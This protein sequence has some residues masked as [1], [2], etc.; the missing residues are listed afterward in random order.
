[1][2][3]KEKFVKIVQNLKENFL[4]LEEMKEEKEIAEF[5]CD[6]SDAIVLPKIDLNTL[7][8]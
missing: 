6:N 5:I 2:Y 1:M 8:H 7:K 3:S 4:L